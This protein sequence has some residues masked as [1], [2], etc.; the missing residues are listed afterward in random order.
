MR[1][2]RFQARHEGKIEYVDVVSYSV[3]SIVALTSQRCRARDA[4]TPIVLFIAQA[5][6]RRTPPSRSELMGGQW[7]LDISEQ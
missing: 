7:R 5:V 1:A 6:S 4:L 2:Q 3:F